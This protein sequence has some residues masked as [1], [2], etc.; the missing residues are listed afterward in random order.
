MADDDLS[1]LIDRIRY[2]IGFLKG[3]FSAIVT[4]GIKEA[5]RIL[6]Q[7]W[8]EPPNIKMEPAGQGG[9][10][11]VATA[12]SSIV[13]DSNEPLGTVARHAHGSRQAT[14]SNQRAIA[15]VTGKQ[16]RMVGRQKLGDRLVTLINDPRA[17]K[18][19]VCPVC[20]A[21]EG[22]TFTLT[23]FQ[24]LVPLHPHCKCK[25]VPLVGGPGER[26]ASVDMDDA[27]DVIMQ[28]V[29]ARVPELWDEFVKD[30]KH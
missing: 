22:M 29:S 7:K 15:A 21:L 26:K 3:F 11:I 16:A 25:W 5:E 30:W 14:P 6:E 24:Q 8:P 13:E 2:A 1:G 17:S 23:E 12:P 9:I 28:K 27:G 18:S 20:E 19:G 4:E 10:S